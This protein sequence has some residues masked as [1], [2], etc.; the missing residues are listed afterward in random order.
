MH[1][2]NGLGEW[3]IQDVL[4]KHPGVGPILEQ[5]GIGCVTCSVGICLLKD[6]VSIHALP[7]EE[8]ARLEREINDHLAGREE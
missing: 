7:A 2:I 3:A 8:E 4:K 5:A 6:V 1:L